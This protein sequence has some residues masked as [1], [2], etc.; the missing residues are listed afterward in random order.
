MS[1]CAPAP[2]C[3]AGLT[4]VSLCLSCPEEPKLDAKGC[5]IAGPRQRHGIPSLDLL[6]VVLHHPEGGKPPLL[7]VCATDSSLPCPPAHCK[8]F[9]AKLL[10]NHEDVSIPGGGL[11]ICLCSALGASLQAAEVSALPTSIPTAP[12][13]EMLSSFDPD[14]GSRHLFAELRMSKKLVLPPK[15]GEC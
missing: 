14:Q 11:C 6:A 9:S 15:Q 8:T 13:T 1:P 10:S 2:D 12:L 4:A 3:L 7:Q 5:A